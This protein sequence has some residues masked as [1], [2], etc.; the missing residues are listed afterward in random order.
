MTRG[1]YF[2]NT[3]VEV[4][5]RLVPADPAPSQ[6]AESVWCG[7]LCLDPNAPTDVVGWS[8][9]HQTAVIN[10]AFAKDDFQFEF[11]RDGVLIRRLIWHQGQWTTVEG[12]VQ[13]WEAP[14]FRS[15]YKLLDDLA[16]DAGFVMQTDA[17]KLDEVRR[18]QSSPM[19]A[20]ASFPK[21][22][23]MHAMLACCSWY[24]LERP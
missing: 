7:A 3:L 2:E 22:I 19:E 10:V 13:P 21:C 11:A 17:S 6:P 4:V 14:V 16:T 9:T 1:L 18:L 5:S 23:P 15:W 20:N 12:E 8:K 24:G